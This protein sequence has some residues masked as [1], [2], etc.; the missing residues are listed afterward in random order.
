[1]KRVLRKSSC[2]VKNAA[3]LVASALLA[4]VLSVSVL[5]EEPYS[6]DFSSQVGA[7]KALNGVNLWSKF[8]RATLEDGQAAA[9]ACHFSTVRLHDAPWDNE[10]MRLVDVHQIFGNLSA[11][12]SD[13]ANYFFKAT[14]DYIAN[15]IKSGAIPVYRLGTSIEHTANKYFAKKPTDMAHYAEICAGIVRH[16]TEG[17]ADGY[18]WDMYWEIWN[19]PNLVPQ[20][21]D[22]E[23]WNSYCKFYETVARRLRSEFPNIKIG[24]P[25]LT[26]ADRNLLKWFA[27]HC[28]EAQ[29]PLD[30]VSWH[31]YAHTPSEVLDP[32]F[33]IRKI[34]DEAG[35]P[36]AELH[37][38][39]WHY[40]PTQ[41]NVVHG[42]NGGWEA[43][44]ELG[45][46]PEGLHGAE[47][48][49]FVE[50]VLTR[51]QDGPLDMSN[52]YAYGLDTWGLHDIVGKPRATYYAFLLF[53]ELITNAPLRVSTSVAT[54][55]V[56]LLGATD[57]SGQ[58]RYLLVSAY[59]EAEEQEL[60][61]KL[62]G[63]QPNGHA[64]VSRIDYDVDLA[65]SEVEYKDGVL[66]LHA[67]KSSVFL[68]RF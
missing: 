15:I 40:F 8:S 2:R 5:G 23:D 37:L 41:W 47:A 64:K 46:S 60:E 13:P 4:S 29:V 26:H 10:G 51:W 17:W 59:K 3:L 18:H 53:G 31:C 62:S 63:V 50:Y 21:W 42:E 9:E 30:F 56:S 11:D 66:K 44:R 33:E 54:E 27:G 16:Y 12:P 22:D 52:Y 49:A 39:E 34:L 61:I 19:E 48:A 57:A 58:K 1:M 25:A 20:M 38:N 6:V 14:D 35:Y 28:H 67:Q 32:P 7:I 68:V 36:N 55:H 45:T 43:K 65:E 24:G